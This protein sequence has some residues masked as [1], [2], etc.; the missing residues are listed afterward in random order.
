MS[1]KKSAGKKKAGVTS[2]AV[3]PGG[4]GASGSAPAEASGAVLA[5]SIS[6]PP[7]F[8]KALAEAEC[9]AELDVDLEQTP[10]PAVAE[11][12]IAAPDVTELLKWFAKGVAAAAEAGSARLNFAASLSKEERAAVHSAIGAAGLAPALE[13]SSE[14]VGEAR[15][16]SVYKKGAAPAK[17]PADPELLERAATLY[18]WA[19]DAGLTSFSRDEIAEQLAAGPDGAGLAAPLAAVWKARSAEQADV[20]ALAAAVEADDAARVAELLKSKPG[21][22]NAVNS[23]TGQPALHAAA[24]VGA[25]A[26]LRAAVAAGAGLEDKDAHGRTA[27]QISRTFEQCDA[28]AAL[29]QLGAHDPEAGKFP[30]NRGV[31]ELVAKT[32]KAAEAPKP[33]PAA[34]AEAPQAEALKAAPA[35]AP[36]LEAPKAVLAAAEAAAKPAPAAAEA[37]APKPATE[38][39]AAKPVAEVTK[40]APSTTES[41][42]EPLKLSAGTLPPVAVPKPLDHH[43]PGEQEARKRF[44]DD[45]LSPTA[46]KVPKGAE[47]VSPQPV[48]PPA[49]AAAPAPPAVAAAAAAPQPSAAAQPAPKA[50]DTAAAPLAV[51]A[52]AAP[53]AAAPVAATAPVASSAPEPAAV[54]DAAPTA[55]AG[56]GGGEGLP[57]KL[58]A[59]VAEGKAW[60]AQHAGFLGYAGVTAFFASITMLALRRR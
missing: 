12:T 16:L 8:W 15:R 17:A 20:A 55:V 9:P 32:V 4:A 7:I 14:G 23:R 56:G 28:E 41:S 50:A 1:R 44:A 58:K 35:A 30:I 54:A 42:V 26:A 13:S 43:K 46:A 57:A 38:A 40:P 34:A 3:K 27:L 39:A 60:A 52:A 36:Q 25:V 53:A 51:A 47:G 6:A 29:L 2:G 21:L 24:R 31:A 49:A 11:G 48:P 18:K 22:V 59:L 19:R 10:A 33:A 5:L 45:A 37:G